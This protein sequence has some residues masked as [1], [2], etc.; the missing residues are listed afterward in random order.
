MTMFDL[1]DLKPKSKKIEQLI[2]LSDEY[3]KRDFKEFDTWDKTT[4]ELIEIYKKCLKENKSYE[5]IYGKT[6]YSIGCEY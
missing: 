2:K 6:I 1:D 4:D 5:L 3:K